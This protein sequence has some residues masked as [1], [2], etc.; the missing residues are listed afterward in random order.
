MKYE[1]SSGGVVVYKSKTGWVL[2]L[3]RDRNGSWTFPKGIVESKEDHVSTAFREIG[4]ETGIT[5][6]TL[7]TDLGSINFIYKNNDLIRK[8]V[9]YFLFE[10]K[11]K[12]PINPQLKEGIT[13]G[14]WVTL[15]DA[16]GIIG[17]P[18]TNRSLLLRAGNYLKKYAA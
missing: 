5:G 18:E 12:Q 17:Y 13:E 15:A 6:L 11:I 2:L 8:T 14:K 1:T 3:I 7:L 9:Y 16:A 10:S 4:E